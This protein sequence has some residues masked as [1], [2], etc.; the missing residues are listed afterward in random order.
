MKRNMFLGVSDKM[1]LEIYT[2][3]KNLLFN[4]MGKSS[5]SRDEFVEI[6]NTNT[7]LIYKGT[8]IRLAAGLP[9][10][11]NFTLTF[12]S[13]V[14]AGVVAN[15]IYDK[16]KNRA[17]KIVINR[18]EIQMDKEEIKRFIEEEIKIEK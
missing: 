16:L 1:E 15:W 8:T 18:R 5:V 4:L 11:I 10:I 7:K 6:P 9:E 17:E 3:D 14:A 13:G 2:H 12:S